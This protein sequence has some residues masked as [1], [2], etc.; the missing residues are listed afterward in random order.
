M[1]TA[2]AQALSP[3]RSCQRSRGLCIANP[4]APLEVSPVRRSTGRP[5]VGLMQIQGSWATVTRAVCKKQNV[6]RALQDP[7]CNV[8]VARHLYNNGGLGHWKATSG[9]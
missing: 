3:Q 2:P 9:S 8:K 5:D 1:G 4:D 6:I 7:S